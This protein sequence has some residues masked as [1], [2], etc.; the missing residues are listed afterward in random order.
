M[1][2]V[3]IA[4]SVTCSSRM[5]SLC[6]IS[7]QLFTMTTWCTQD[8]NKPSSVCLNLGDTQGSKINLLSSN[9][10]YV[11]WLSQICGVLFFYFSHCYGTRDCMRPKFYSSRVI[12]KRSSDFML[13]HVIWTSQTDATSVLCV[14]PVDS[15]YL[16][17]VFD[18]QSLNSTLVVWDNLL[19]AYSCPRLLPRLLQEIKSPR[20]I[21]GSAEWEA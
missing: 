8:A 18:Y 20:E 7:I 11:C 16:C 5:V 14:F 2:Q 17:N 10:L 13:H 19:L 12:L 4:I 1:K 6:L 3:L 15:L 9:L 21:L